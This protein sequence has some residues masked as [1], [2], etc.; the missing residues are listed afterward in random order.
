MEIEDHMEQTR[1]LKVVLS[2][3]ACA[4]DRGSEPGVGWGV[5][6]RL[7][8]DHEVWLLT[9]AANVP[10]LRDLGPSVRIIPIDLPRVPRAFQGN[11]GL[12]HV[13]YFLWQIKTREV[14]RRVC[15]EVR[16][17]LIHHLTY[18]NSWIPSFLGNLG[19]PFIWSAGAALT[20]PAQL[21]RTMSPSSRILEALRNLLVRSIG[22]VT[23][24]WVGQQA[25]LILT[26][27]P[28]HSFDRS[29]T[30]I[31]HLGGLEPSELHSF[32]SVARSPDEV[33]R[34]CSVGRLVGLK[35][36]HLAIAAVARCIPI[37][38]N[39][40]FVIVGD[41]I[42]RKRLEKLARGLGCGEHVRFVGWV[43]REKVR[44]WLSASNLFLHLSLRELFGYSLL[45]AMASGV[46]TICLALGGPA[47]FLPSDACVKI[48]PG[49]VEDIV[50]SSAEAIQSLATMSDERSDLGRR[51]AE[52]ARD[53]GSWDRAASEIESFYRE[54]GAA[55]VGR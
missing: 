33:F 11:F 49:P 50:Q 51:G 43:D 17:D 6:R 26:A 18:V 4:P 12:H 36:T 34:I 45:E 40:E 42:E 44:S 52:W 37:V 55:G 7:A 32:P 23:R 30:K 27:S 38:P 13:Y 53:F 15:R 29:R 28:A 39:L 41:G 1:P 8:A 9:N 3:F 5:L 31:I 2:A 14:A 47:H 54:I 16:P 35:G 24:K 22:R 10:Y 21:R 46:P 25:D 20:V 48:Q 19:V